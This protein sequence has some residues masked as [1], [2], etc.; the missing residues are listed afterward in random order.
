MSQMELFENQEI[1]AYSEQTQQIPSLDIANRKYIGSK[2]RLVDFLRREIKSRVPVI[3][4]FFDA[5]SG[6]GVVAHRFRHDAGR[7][8]A[9]DLLYCNFVV[10][11]TFLSSNT[12]NCSL[13]QDLT[14][15]SQIERL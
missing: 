6:T 10:N 2:A 5:F 15:A 12:T 8:I 4:T 14:A 13:E 7:V 9:N 11:R 1:L 3:G